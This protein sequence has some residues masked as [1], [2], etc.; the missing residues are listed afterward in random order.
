MNTFDSTEHPF[1]KS[2]RKLTMGLSVHETGDRR[3]A[4]VVGT[5]EQ[6]QAFRARCALEAL[7]SRVW[8]HSPASLEDKK[9][10]HVWRAC[11]WYAI[12]ADPEPRYPDDLV[13]WV[14]PPNPSRRDLLALQAASDLDDGP[15]DAE[16]GEG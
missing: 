1:T 3:A 14:R 2:L 12:P 8:L 13:G 9:P 5:P 16:D 6:V 15:L 11:L 4:A 10:R 7:G